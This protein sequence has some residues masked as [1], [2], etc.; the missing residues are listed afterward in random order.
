VEKNESQQEPLSHRLAVTDQ[1][2]SL[3]ATVTLL[4]D[5]TDNINIELAGDGAEGIAPLVETLRE[6]TATVAAPSERSIRLSALAAMFAEILRGK[7]YAVSDLPSGDIQITSNLDLRTGRTFSTMSQLNPFAGDAPD[8]R[9]ALAAAIQAVPARFRDDALDRI[10]LPLNAGNHA[11]AAAALLAV[12]Q[13]GLLAFADS[14]IL[15][16]A[17]RIQLDGLSAGDVKSIRW[18]RA[19]LADKLKRSEHAEADV[20]ALLDATDLTL[21]ERANLELCMGIA[22]RKRGA[23]G[24]AMGYWRRVAMNGDL[25]AGTRAWA[26]RN[27]SKSL[28]PAGTEAIQAARASADA[29]LEAGEKRDAIGSLLALCD[30]LEHHDPAQAVVELDSLLELVNAPGLWGQLERAALHHALGNRFQGMRQ[31]RRALAEAEAAIAARRDL[32]GAEDELIS[33]L[34]LATFAAEHLG[35]TEK[36]ASYTAEANELTRAHGSKHFQLAGRIAQMLS[37]FDPAA[38]DQ[39]VSD[40]RATNQADLWSAAKLAV[41]VG[42]QQLDPLIRLARLEELNGELLRADV[43]FGTRKPV[44][45]GIA[46]T[47]A[48]L[49]DLVSSADWL[50]DILKEDAGD[51]DARDRLA[52][53][54]RQDQRWGDLAIFLKRQIVVHGEQPGLL[55]WYGQALLESGDASGAVT[56]LSLAIKIMP[57]D[58]PQRQYALNL[59]DRALDLGGTILP[60]TAA[61]PDAPVLRAELEVALNDYRTFISGDKRM[62]FWRKDGDDHVWT[63]QPERQAQDLLHTFLKA[64]FGERIDVYEELGAGAGRIDLLLRFQGGLQTIVE[65]KLCGFNY[66]SAYAASGEDQIRHYMDARNV[67]LGYLVVHDARLSDQG[68]PLLEPADGPNTVIEFLINVMPRMPAKRGRKTKP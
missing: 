6:R 50:T 43:P 35:E 66:T 19:A 8:I 47:H 29:F 30:I 55:T 3:L 62:T 49:G 2:G 60:P 9:P 18:I 32:Y 27:L 1:A 26:W 68:A 22:L 20:Q 21:Q 17:L 33:S 52:A 48:K 14:A 34:H 53:T 65:L 16:A 13:D 24:A 57:T 46:Q 61:D 59:R 45:L 31:H 41:I 63:D 39:L 58:A 37:D 15:D 54:L 10:T 42:D 7:G 12:Q 5:A 44:M 67:H 11:G 25:D 28:P 51:M 23:I 64:R 38:A 40:A 4:V 36:A 56:H